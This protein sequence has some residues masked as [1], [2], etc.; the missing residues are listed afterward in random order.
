MYY[1]WVGA[2]EA[3]SLEGVVK[4]RGRN[5]KESDLGRIKEPYILSD[6]HQIYFIGNQMEF[7]DY[8]KSKKIKPSQIKEK[9]ISGHVLPGFVE[10]H[11]HL[12]F[13]GDRIK[14]FELRSQGV[15]YQEIAQRG[16]GLPLQ[17]SR[18]KRLLQKNF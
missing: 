4:K 6:R 13:S 8:R 3:L 14:E 12:V 2:D 17:L 7:E 16:G 18:L 5:V 11:T 1:L 9:K 15:S 10:S